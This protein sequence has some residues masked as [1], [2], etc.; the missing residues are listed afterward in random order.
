MSM[1]N[2]AKA[3]SPG[4]TTQ[5]A[6]SAPDFLDWRE[7]GLHVILTELASHANLDLDYV[8][9]WMKRNRLSGDDVCRFLVK[10]AEEGL[11]PFECF[12]TALVG[13]QDPILNPCYRD[14]CRQ[15]GNQ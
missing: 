15:T 5:P 12:A 8:E 10:V 11:S 9:N 6:P 7:A 4:A 13:L 2:A 14:L 3:W 1:S